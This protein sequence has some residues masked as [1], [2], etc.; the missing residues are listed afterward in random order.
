[1]DIVRFEE[2]LSS[3]GLEAEWAVVEAEEKADMGKFLGRKRDT[4]GEAAE[5]GR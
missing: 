5:V 1:M 2:G 3:D 4:G